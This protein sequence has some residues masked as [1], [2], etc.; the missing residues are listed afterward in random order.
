MS[1][2]HLQQAKR[3]KNAEFYT[4]AEDIY[5]EVPHYHAYLRGKTVLC[6][7]DLPDESEFVRYFRKHYNEIGLAGL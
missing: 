5:K 6:N 4:L 3:E 1:I 7:C 2:K